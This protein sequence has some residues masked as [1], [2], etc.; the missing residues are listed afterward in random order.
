MI[1]STKSFSSFIVDNETK[2]VKFINSKFNFFQLVK[3]EISSDNRIRTK[4]FLICEIEFD[5]KQSLYKN[6]HQR[7]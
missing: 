2:D 1:K 3:A 6:N 4:N 5:L 7:V